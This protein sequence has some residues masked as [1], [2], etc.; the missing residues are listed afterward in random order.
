MHHN[1]IIMFVRQE[2]LNDEHIVQTEIIPAKQ[3]CSKADKALRK[4]PGLL[5]G[6]MNL[7][8]SHL[9]KYSGSVQLST[10]M[11]HQL[12]EKIISKTHG[13]VMHTIINPNISSPYFETLQTNKST[14]NN[15]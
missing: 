3:C 14:V 10:E 1:S 5:M 4:R 15:S 9:S 7:P 6:G 11:Q 2:L 13:N 8:L 12:E